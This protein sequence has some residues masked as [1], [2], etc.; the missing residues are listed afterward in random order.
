MTPEAA[1]N[2]FWSGAE[3]ACSGALSFLSA[4]VVAR[5][6]GPAELGLGAAAVAMHV[7]LWVVVNALFAD[8]LVQQGATDPA[9]VSAALWAAVAVG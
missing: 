3:A 1:R 8:A 5:M 9:T 7:L 4:C 6:V 2:V